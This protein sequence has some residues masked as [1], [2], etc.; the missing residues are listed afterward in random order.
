MTINRNFFFGQV[1]NTLFG[2]KLSQSQVDGM[3]A[4]L[5]YWET[6]HAARDDRWL[7]YL[8]GTAFHETDRKMQPIHEY[9]G[10]AYFTARYDPPPDGKFPKIA[11]ALGN[12]QRG[13]GALFHG[14][15][16]V[17]LTGRRNYADW[18]NRLSVNL[19][20]VPDLAL[21][22]DIATAVLI[23]GAILGSFT[24]R[25]LSRYFGPGVEDWVNA[26]RIINGMDR[27]QNIAGYG[28][29]FYAAISYTV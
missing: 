6:K 25:P 21:R 19:L 18:A 3:A 23:E 8:L 1:R 13:D 29:Q 11:A 7:A 16:F 26:R 15:G 27:A 24:G 20:A 14:R 12:N 5:E 9:G 28:K 4:I 17:Q 22:I 2:G 10:A